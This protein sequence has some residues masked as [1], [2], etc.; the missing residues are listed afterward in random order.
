MAEKNK[1]LKCSIC[2]CML[3]PEPDGVDVLNPDGSQAVVIRTCNECWQEIKRALRTRE[4]YE[5]EFHR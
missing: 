3:A 2:G 5:V 4:T 1:N